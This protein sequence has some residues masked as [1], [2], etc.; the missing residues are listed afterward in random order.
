[1]DGE[2]L[3]AEWDEHGLEVRVWLDEDTDADGYA[4]LRIGD[5]V[6]LYRL[7]RSALDDYVAEHDAALREYRSGVADDPTQQGVLDRIR[8]D[9]D[10]DADTH[11]VRA[12][13]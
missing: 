13:L 6:V 4:T 9:Y 5:P 2:I 10:P 3:S 1:M 11:S 8:G 7:V 12:D